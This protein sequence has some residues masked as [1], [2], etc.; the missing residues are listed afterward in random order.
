MEEEAVARLAAK[1]AEKKLKHVDSVKTLRKNGVETLEY[2][3]NNILYQYILH[4]RDTKRG[5]GIFL[6]KL[7]DFLVRHRDFELLRKR[8][9][10]A[11]VEESN[12][13]AFLRG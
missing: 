4:P 13:R 5:A 8:D 1:L 7:I 6:W 12:S 10:Q 11:K 3:Q 2:E 9:F